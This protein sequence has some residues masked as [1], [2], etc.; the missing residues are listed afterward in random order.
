MNL[1]KATKTTITNNNKSKPH[2][3]SNLTKGEIDWLNKFKNW[4]DMIITKADKGGAVVIMNVDDYIKKANRQLNNTEF[5][6]KVVTNPTTT[7]NDMVN[8]TI[9]KFVKEK[10][11]S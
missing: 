7:D 8:N 5:Y 9:W 4:D 2:T 10:L 1:P 3:H 6:T 11:L